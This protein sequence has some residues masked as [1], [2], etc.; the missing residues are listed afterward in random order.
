M[1]TVQDVFAFINGF[2]PFAEALDFDNSGLLVGDGQQSVETAVLA[3]DIA[4]SVVEEAV[5]KGARLIVS[6][7]PV[8]FHPMAQITAEDVPAMLLHVSRRKGGEA[9]YRMPG[10]SWAIPLLL[11]YGIGAA[12]CHTLTVLNYLPAFK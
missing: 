8:I 2:A 12:V 3:L 5:Q 1:T 9:L 4:A 10:A 6:H 7:H 11:V